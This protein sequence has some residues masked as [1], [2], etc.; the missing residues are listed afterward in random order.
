MWAVTIRSTF[1]KSFSAFTIWT[2]VFFN[3]TTIIMWT[4]VSACTIGT[5]CLSTWTL[6]WIYFW[7]FKFIICTKSRSTSVGF[8]W[9]R[10][11][12]ND[13]TIFEAL[14]TRT[15]RTKFWQFFS[16][17]GIYFLIFFLKNFSYSFFMRE[18]LL[19]KSFV[20]NLVIT[21]L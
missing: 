17:M 4:I 21:Y 5:S 8:I 3:V 11:S 18:T 2:L 13:T 19:Q 1:S 12:L 20:F 15:I 9:V 6:F 10:A 16:T 14:F 7:T